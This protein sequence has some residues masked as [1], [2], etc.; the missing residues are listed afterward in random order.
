MLK[1]ENRDEW[2]VWIRCSRF[3]GGGYFGCF[4]DNGL[5][6]LTEERGCNAFTQFDLF[7]VCAAIHP[8]MD[9]WEGRR[10]DAPKISRWIRGL[11]C[12]GRLGVFFSRLHN[13]G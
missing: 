1:R 5:A 3:Y 9:S 13:S 8:R 7:A 11:G 2:L 4:G 6:D 12:G 10:D